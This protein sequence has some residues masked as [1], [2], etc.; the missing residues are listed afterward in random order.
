[1]IYTIVVKNGAGEYGFAVE[2]NN[3]TVTFCGSDDGQIACEMI[4]DNY[5]DYME[6]DLTWQTTAVL[7]FTQCQ[8]C[9]CEF[10][11]W[12]ELMLFVV[13]PIDSIIV[14]SSLTNTLQYALKIEPVLYDELEKRIIKTTVFH[15]EEIKPN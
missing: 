14:G 11:D 8:T 1:M 9:V 12:E 5:N 6:K 7:H 10:K 3:G 4:P 2:N 15:E 13:D